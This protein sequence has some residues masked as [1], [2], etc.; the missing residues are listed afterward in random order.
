MNIL[1]IKYLFVGYPYI[2][3]VRELQI[4]SVVRS[5]YSLSYVRIYI[6]IYIYIDMCVL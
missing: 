1:F 4:V 5:L 2:C 6:Y 3:M